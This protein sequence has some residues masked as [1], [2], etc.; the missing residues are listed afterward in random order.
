MSQSANLPICQSANESWYAV[1]TQPHRESVAQDTLLRIGAQVFYPRYRQRVILHGYKREVVRPLFPSYLF[2]SFDVEREFRA[3]QYARGVRRVVTFGG[4]PAIVPGDLLASIQE[5]MKDGYVKL[6]PPELRPGQ[7]VEI[8][9]GPFAGH[10]GIFQA[11]LSG[12]ER[13]AILLDTLKFNAR[14]VI[15]RA[16]IRPI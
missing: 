13:V 7:R 14:A 2:V 5:R 3:V 8:V 10:T 9:A 15:D 16:T 1:Q 4:E 12:A 6:N 11:N